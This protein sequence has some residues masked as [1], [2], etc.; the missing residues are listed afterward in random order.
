MRILTVSIYKKMTTP[1]SLSPSALLPVDTL[2]A[3]LLV[4]AY[5]T[6]HAH[7]T[8]SLADALGRIIAVEVVAEMD[9]PPF[10]NSAM[11]GYACTW[12][13]GLAGHTLLVGA[14]SFA[15]HGA[16]DLV[17]GTAVRIL[18]GAPMPAGADTVIMQ[19]NVTL[20]ESIDPAQ[21]NQILINQSPKLGENIRRAGQDIAN[22][23]TVCAVGT[24]LGAA[25]IGLLA[26]MGITEITVYRPLRVSV[27]AT[28]DELVAGGQPLLAG[29]IYNSNAP[30]VHALLTQLSVQVQRVLQVA[31]QPA[32]L[33]DA[34]LQSA[35]DSDLILTTGGA[36]V[37]DADHLKPVLQAIGHIDQWKVAIKPGKPLVW[38]SVNHA[39]SAVPVIGLPGNPQSVWVTF[40]IVVLPY[41]KALQG[42]RSRL[43]P[44]SLKVPA[45]F[46]RPRAQERREYLRVQLVDGALTPHN[47]QSSGAL[48]SAAW[49]D[50]FAVIETGQ[51]VAVGDLVEYVPMAGVLG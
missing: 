51:V 34:L 4:A 24:R 15:G 26:S 32:L 5:A 31:D 21:P 44:Q 13:E 3:R 11:D 30:L 27:V 45:A 14:S 23:A 35:A 50:G 25:E 22:G 18:T 48:W 47:N 36:S 8:C 43:T 37:G 33:R 42:Q 39:G 29:Q 19:E 1:G 7:E 10:D 2:I 38:G 49:A 6:Q 41:L 9:S 20:L 28:G 17:Y 46:S 40:L 12:Q 16:A